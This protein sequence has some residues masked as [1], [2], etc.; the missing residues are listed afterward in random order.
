MG[1]VLLCAPKYA[2]ELAERVGF[3]PTEGLHL[4]LISS[5]ARSTGLRHLS[6]STPAR[7]RQR[8]GRTLWN[9]AASYAAGERRCVAA[10]SGG[11][12]PVMTAWVCERIEG[13][14]PGGAGP[15]GLEE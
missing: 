13:L 11:A 5:Q 8:R 15:A 7:E 10:H 12:G 3:E 1:G 2:E 9:L 14:T 6:A 4:H